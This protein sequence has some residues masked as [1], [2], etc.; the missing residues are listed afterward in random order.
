MAKNF[1]V[2]ISKLDAEGHATLD[3]WINSFLVCSCAAP[4][5][6]VDALNELPE[7]EDVSEG[8]LTKHSQAVDGE[9]QK[10][11]EAILAEVLI[12]HGFADRLSGVGVFEL[13]AYGRSG[14]ISAG[15]R[16]FYVLQAGTSP[17]LYVSDSLAAA[18]G[19]AKVIAATGQLTDPE[20]VAIAWPAPSPKPPLRAR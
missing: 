2:Q 13:V 9:W 10:G 15:T 17:A 18:F 16:R 5:K 4:I 7:I 14:R 1:F 12:A 20:V 19:A 11:L 6:V 8:A 3:Q